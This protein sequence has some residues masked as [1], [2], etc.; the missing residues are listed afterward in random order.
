MFLCVRIT[1]LGFPVVPEV[2]LQCVGTTLAQA[3]GDVGARSQLTM[4]RIESW[5]RECGYERRNC[6]ILLKEGT[7]NSSEN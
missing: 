6:Y 2:Y 1:P 3:R 7:A 5:V 4:H